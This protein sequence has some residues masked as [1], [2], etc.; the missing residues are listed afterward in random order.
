M[1]ESY[2][3]L[4]WGPELARL[5]VGGYMKSY[6]VLIPGIAH[7]G[8]MRAYAEVIYIRRESIYQP[9]HWTSTRSTFAVSPVDQ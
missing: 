1:P 2:T 4:M 7:L 9:S 8:E 6:G 5:Q 3:P